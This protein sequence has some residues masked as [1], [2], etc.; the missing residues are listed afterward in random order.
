MENA[1]VLKGIKKYFPG[2]RALDWDEEDTAEFCAGEIHGLVGENGAGKSTLFQVLKGIYD[3][4][5]GEMTLFGEPYDP[6]TPLDA[7]KAGISIIMQVPNFASYLTVA[8]NI[9]LGQDRK[10]T[11][12]GVINW[13]EQNK[14]AAE[15]LKKCHFEHIRPTDVLENLSFEERKQ[16]EI[17]RALSLDPKVLLVD[18]TSA[19]VSK[20]SVESLYELLREQRDKGVAVVYIS[21]FID[22]VHALCDRVTVLRDGRLVDKMNV[23]DITEQMIINSMVGRDISS[24]S[25]RSEDSSSIGEI[26]LRVK[27][28]TMEPVFRNINLNVRAGEI[29]G[30]AGIG[31]CG[32]EEFV[33]AIF[34]YETVKSGE[35]IYKG[36]S[37]VMKSPCEAIANNIGYIPK[38]RDNEGLFLLYDLV[39]NISSAKVKACAK[40]GMVDLKGEKAEAQEAVEKYRI[41]TPGIYTHLEDLS[42]GNKQ[43]VV[44]AKWIRNNS[45]LLMACSPTRGVDVGVKYEIYKFLEIQKNEGKAILLTSDELP[46]LIGMC[47]R[48]YT[49]KNGE[50]TY[51][52][53]R[54]DGFSEEAILSRMV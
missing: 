45:D 37:R 5:A 22:E 36:K 32:S 1:V 43:K 46:E 15:V 17:A 19:A 13:K 33:R 11:K 52:F 54:T 29:V 49:F 47:D 50:V 31:G 20:D 14:K 12:L 6:R 27:D 53:R 2:T 51:E 26:M 21:H 9:F 8:E 38:D 3:K 39:W 48:I 25:Y 41:K 44:I 40:K 24:S 7:E 34:G 18:E 4:T 16:V 42:G 35:M 30:I 10:F 23:A 28:F